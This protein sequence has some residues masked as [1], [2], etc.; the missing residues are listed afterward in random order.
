M[1]AD[2]SHVRTNQ[3]VHGVGND[4]VARHSHVAQACAY[5]HES[6]SADTRMPRKAV[7]QQFR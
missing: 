4:V 1:L 2:S 3:P 7:A 5:A 6:E